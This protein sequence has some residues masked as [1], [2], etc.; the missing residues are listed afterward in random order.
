MNNAYF[1]LSDLANVHLYRLI[2]NFLQLD[3]RLQ[4]LGGKRIHGLGMADE[5][6]GLEEVEP[7]IHSFWSSECFKK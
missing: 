3:S 7:W 2:V 5:R 6:E 4:A 1:F